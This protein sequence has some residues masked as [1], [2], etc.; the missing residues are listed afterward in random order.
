VPETLT[1]GEL[2]A[3]IDRSVRQAFP[4]E[5]WV[6]GAISGLKRTAAGHV[7]FDLV[8]PVGLG[9][10]TASVPVALFAA[11]RM[12]VN[13]ILTR[14]GGAVRMTD[15]TEIRIRGEVGYY[16]RNGRVQVV[17]SLI[18]P[19]YTL[20]RR[21]EARDRLLRQ[22]AAEG[23]LEAN[24]QNPLSV[25]PLRVA[26][27]T[28]HGSAAHADFGD[29]LHRSGYRFDLRVFD[30]R[31]Q[32]TDAVETLVWALDEAS[33]WGP[34]V[35]A[36][37]RGGGARTDLGAFDHEAVARAVASSPVPVF[38]GIGHETD[39]SVCDE[40][41]HTAAKTPTACAQ[42]VV[43]RVRDFE[44]R[45]DAATDR[46]RRLTDQRLGS[47]ERELHQLA[48]RTTRAGLVALTRT[49]DAL[50]ALARRIARAAVVGHRRAEEHL[51]RQTRR[52]VAAGPAALSRA[53]HPLELAATRLRAVDPAETLRRGWSITRTG[54]G[55]LVTD[56]AWVAPGQALVT[57]VAGGELHSVATAAGGDAEPEPAARTR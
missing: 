42:L 30:A 50:D 53:G 36:V 2:C 37:V 45:V 55:H 26:L 19:A 38:T 22:L 6:S 3:A 39:R 14:S 8:D 13:R 56:P 34:D 23:L 4:E 29:E 5:V 7:Y 21:A 12:L 15:G 31:V 9:E 25:L 51:G 16:P 35:I 33:R 1:V 57:T 24:R 18:D 48:R 52:L 27:I 41:A 17:M 54:D 28:S 10:V 43:A 46:L 49:D 40:V 11:K 47:A 44:Q 20:G 32:G